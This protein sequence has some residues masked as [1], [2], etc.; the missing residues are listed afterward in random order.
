MPGMRKIDVVKRAMVGLIGDNRK[1]VTIDK[2]YRRVTDQCR[3]I[4][5]YSPSW[6]VFIDAIQA[7]GGTLSRSNEAGFVVKL[8]VRGKL[9]K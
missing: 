9:G 8:P 6:N 4:G 1:T 7:N 3:R 5:V 2:L